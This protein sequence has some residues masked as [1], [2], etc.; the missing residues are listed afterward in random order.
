MDD[1][2]FIGGDT[3]KLLAIWGKSYFVHEV[4]VGLEA[5]HVLKRY[6]I[7]DVELEVFT[8]NDESVWLTFNIARHKR[9]RGAS[10]LANLGAGV[11]E[12]S[13][14]KKIFALASG[15]YSLSVISPRYR[16]DSSTKHLMLFFCDEFLALWIVR[17]Y[18]NLPFFVARSNEL[19][20]GRILDACDL[21]HEVG[22]D[23]TLL[24]VLDVSNDH[25]VLARVG[26]VGL[27]HV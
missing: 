13:F 17:P 8:A 3:H 26:D 22:E 7:E 6:S 5:L 15:Y 12:N 16:L 9:G 24:G 27:L 19:A 14:C 4:R 25:V 11:Y 10:K 20:I 23:C 2:G 21:V 18:P 1:D